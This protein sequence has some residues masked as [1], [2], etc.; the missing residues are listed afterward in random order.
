MKKKKKK[1]SEIST[2]LML[3]YILKSEIQITKQ[4][5]HL[6]AWK[7]NPTQSC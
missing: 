4:T 7:K 5:Y 3:Q 1:E 6:K 2:G